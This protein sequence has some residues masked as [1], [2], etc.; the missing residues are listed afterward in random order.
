[1]RCLDYA[2]A[3]LS[4]DVLHYCSTDDADGVPLS[5]DCSLN[6]ELSTCGETSPGLFDCIAPSDTTPE[7]PEAPDEPEEVVD[8]AYELWTQAHPILEAGCSGWL[9]HQYS[10]F[11][12][13]DLDAAYQV[14]LDKAFADNILDAIVEGRMPAN[15][16]G[17][18]ICTGDP[19]VD[20]DPRCLTQEELDIVSAWVAAE[21][22]T[23]G[24]PPVEDPTEDT[25]NDDSKD[26][27][28]ANE[29]GGDSEPT[30]EELPIPTFWQIHPILEAG[31]SGFFCHSG[32]LANTD[33]NAAYESI[34]S[35]DLCEPIL[36]AVQS[37]SMPPGKGCT[38]DP[39]LDANIEGC[40]NAE[41]HA[42][43]LAWVT[44]GDDACAGP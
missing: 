3:C 35:K 40:L 9:C 30:I 38:G 16:F 8:A 1:M 18:P 41:E 27:T 42:L 13:P 24:V 29:G 11:A 2:G 36:T 4:G 26:D 19:S 6:A 33:I 44:G 22:G 34:V 31:C 21:L 37:G 28:P 32:G 39:E 5:I 14:V 20:T 15:N 23:S 12:Q 17:L 25:T 7:I 10:G 43:L